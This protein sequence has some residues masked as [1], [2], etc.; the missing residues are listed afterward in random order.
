VLFALGA[1]VI[2]ALTS[3]GLAMVFGRRRAPRIVVPDTIEELDEAELAAATTGG[4][5]DRA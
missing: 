3:I 2:L 4:S 1:T 5:P